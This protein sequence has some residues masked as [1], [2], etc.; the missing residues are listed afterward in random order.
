MITLFLENV[1]TSTLKGPYLYRSTGAAFALLTLLIIC[2]LVTVK[3][4]DY[5][6][7]VGGNVNFNPCFEVHFRFN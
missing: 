1:V 5:I 4:F 3:S 7:F 6:H 2:V